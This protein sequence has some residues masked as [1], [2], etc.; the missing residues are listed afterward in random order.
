MVK[1]EQK[2]Q[3][4]QENLNNSAKNQYFFMQPKPKPLIYIPPSHLN[5]N[6]S[7]LLLKNWEYFDKII[8][9]C[10]FHFFYFISQFFQIFNKKYHY[11]FYLNLKS[12]YPKRVLLKKIGH[13][14]F[15]FLSALNIF[16]I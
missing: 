16:Y 13:F 11:F 1:N 15:S 6:N 5:N 12:D 2:S 9:N 3:F 4:L 8:K 14:D 7:Q 10:V